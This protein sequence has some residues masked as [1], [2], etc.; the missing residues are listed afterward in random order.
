MLSCTCMVIRF[1][2][3]LGRAAAGEHFVI[4]RRSRPLA[5]LISPVEWEQLQRLE[6][7]TTLL[8]H[9]S[10]HFGRIAGLGLEDW[11]Q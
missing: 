1:S 8:T 3:V 7:K 5:V 9:N 6:A 4:H 11:L 10:R 2:E